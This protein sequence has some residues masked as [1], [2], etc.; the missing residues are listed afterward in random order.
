MPNDLPDWTGQQLVQLISA[1]GQFLGDVSQS[2]PV[3]DVLNETIS[4][5]PG[6]AA[7]NLGVLATYKPAGAA[8]IAPVS[9]GAATVGTNLAVTPP[10]GVATTAGNFAGALVRSR[11]TGE[12]TT[13]SV[14]WVK[15]I[16]QLNG[17]EWQQI[18]HKLNIGAAEAAP[19]FT[20]T[21]GVSPMHAQVG[22]WS[23]VAVAAALERTGFTS[24][25]LLTMT[26]SA[27]SP[28]AVLGNL[29]LTCVGWYLLTD[30]QATFVDTFT[31]NAV[32]VP[33]GN[34]H[35]AYFANGRASNFTYAIV[36]QSKVALPV[37][38]RAWDYDAA[39]TSTPVA[40]SQATITLA[41]T[42]GKAWRAAFLA[43]SIV[44]NAATASNIAA[45]LIDGATGIFSWYLGTTAAIGSTSHME[46]QFVALKGTVGN[47]MIFR[48]NA[49]AAGNLE[50]VNIAAYL[51]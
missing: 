43:A 38:V 18:W 36:P 17:S 41:A 47:A 39:G 30:G 16:S 4:Y 25:N 35:S 2:P 14:G 15:A 34:V 12:P 51:Q 3:A 24:T 50:A 48:F 32:A 6:I 5:A 11:S 33:M 44:A 19:A 45:N 10:F 31:N 20:C 29:I 26:V 42:P 1:N 23:G 40:G 37:G 46:Q 7:P 49:G 28:D 8:A 13:V 22:E 9:M 27:G 21:G